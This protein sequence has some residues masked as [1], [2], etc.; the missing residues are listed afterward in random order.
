MSYFPEIFSI[1]SLFEVCC[2]YLGNRFPAFS[3]DVPA[4]PNSLASSSLFSAKSCKH[5]PLPYLICVWASHYSEVVK[6][7][8]KW[9]SFSVYKTDQSFVSLFLTC[10]FCFEVRTL[11][12][13]YSVK[14]PFPDSFLLPWKFLIASATLW[15]NRMKSVWKC[16]RVNQGSS[17]ARYALSIWVLRYFDCCF[18][19]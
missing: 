17:L 18:R 5:T 13:L 2:W 4:A 10:L 12:P 8:K 19:W 3:M 1:L 9:P 11:I 14:L 7:M 6:V 15:K 16:S